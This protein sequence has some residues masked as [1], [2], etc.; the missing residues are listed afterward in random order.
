MKHEINTS[1]NK[2]FKGYSKTNRKYN[3]AFSVY[4]ISR[5]RLNISIVF[6]EDLLIFLLI[7]DICRLA[8][9]SFH[10]STAL[11]PVLVRYKG[12]IVILMKRVR[13]LKHD[14]LNIFFLVNQYV[15]SV[16]VLLA[17]SPLIWVTSDNRH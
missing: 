15:L 17:I 10:N 2:L 4:K 8:I 5:L 9:H 14:G 6:V 12:E 7:L 1:S 3:V 13:A 11:L 16:T